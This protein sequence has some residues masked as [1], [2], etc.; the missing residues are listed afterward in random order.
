MNDWLT[1]WLDE[2]NLRE[3]LREAFI[4]KLNHK[5]PAQCFRLALLTFNVTASGNGGSRRIR[6]FASTETALYICLSVLMPL[7][8]SLR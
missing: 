2:L 5:S 6:L 8:G 1:G 3:C 7:G 4:T